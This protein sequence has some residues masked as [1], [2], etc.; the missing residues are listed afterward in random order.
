MTVKLL[1]YWTIINSRKDDYNKFVLK[2][3]IPGVNQLGLHTVAGWCVLV[4]AYSEIVMECVASDL[5]R[6]EQALNDPRYKKLK[7]DLLNSIKSYKT[8]VLVETGKVSSYSTDIA[9]DTVKF[10]QTWNLI[11]EKKEAYGQFTRKEYYPLMEELGIVIAGEWEVL[12]GD[13]PSIIC[14]GRVNNVSTLIQNLQSK[15][16]R[17][18]KTMLKE[19]IEDYQSRILTFHIQ[20]MKG[21]KSASYRLISD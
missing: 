17:E 6:L 11:G 16:F 7:S 8:K 14:E 13:S 2:K 3:F 18:S 5:D 1:H 20:K 19:Y 9:E 4:G 21:Y 10:N 15:K 12:I